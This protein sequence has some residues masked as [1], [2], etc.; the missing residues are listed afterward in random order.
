MARHLALAK[1]FA[2]PA[3]LTLLVVF[4]WSPAPVWGQATTED[5]DKVVY[6]FPPEGLSLEEAIQIAGTSTGRPFK[7]N[8]QD[9][10]NKPKI[11]V[12]GRIVVPRDRIYEFWQAI[13]VT[14]G[15][16]MVPMGPDAGDFI[17][18]ELVQT[19]QLIK[20][21]ANFVSVDEL[22]KYQSKA[23]EVIMTTIPLKH[24]KVDSVRNAVAQLMVNRTSEFSMEV[25]SANAMI[26]VG[27]APTVY[28][29]YQIMMAMDVPSSAATLKF[30]IVPLKNAVA[31]ELV[32]MLSELITTT[33]GAAAPGQPRAPRAP[34]E[35]VTAATEIPEPKI[36]ADPR[37]NAIVIYAVDA[38]M[39]EV[40]RLIA[41]LD[42]EVTSLDSNIR[43]F[44]LKNT[45]ADDMED[46]LKDLLQQQTSRTGRASNT[47]SAGGGQP[48]SASEIGQ[49]VTIVGDVHTNSLLITCTRTRFDEIAPIIEMLDKR[50]P[51]V[52]V[53]A[54]IAE[55]SDN[56]LRALGV[57]LSGIQGGSDRFRFGGLTG[58]G[59]SEIT[60]TGGG[61]GTGTGGTG[62]GGGSGTGTSPTLPTG[63]D[64]NNLARVPNVGFSGLLGGII[65]SDGTIPLLMSMMQTKQKVNLLSNASVLTNDNEMSHISVGREVAT[66][67]NS[68]DPSGQSRTGFQDYQKAELKLEISPHISTD[69][70]LRLELLLLVEAFVQ[71]S[72]TTGLP[73]DKT[74]REFKGSVTV[75]SGKTVVIGGLVQDNVSE[76]ETSVPFLSEIPLLGELFKSQTRNHERSTLYLFVTPTILS[77]F[78]T[79]ED[80]SYGTKMEVLRLHGNLTLVD[81]N[82]RAVG[83]DA[84][85]LNVEDIEESGDLDMPHYVP[86]APLEADGKQGAAT[87]QPA[88]QPAAPVIGTG[89]T[90]PASGR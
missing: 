4:A 42:T 80:I 39:S 59:L 13:F 6:T 70:Y 73:P 15:F 75:P 76:A 68:F 55:L 37:T 34:G 46:T 69:N 11:M 79:L 35:G 12:T 84:P 85:G 30:D 57:E 87:A 77:D 36:I 88:T 23:G 21:R 3:L 17:Q 5:K 60:P 10:K 2:I 31:E 51:Q 8:D 20:Q 50:R 61:S 67:Q 63:F 22:K 44:F 72:A 14:Q 24:V 82:F 53:H 49:E 71:N 56:A 38:D 27:F 28:A 86:T 18:V 45:N 58:F 32:A 29:V 78:K 41:A 9:F 26:I 64:F 1:G 43:I 89:S 81:P 19:S 83:F 25:P 7:F 33:G 74:S 66:A 54:A 90:P 62:T 65:Q 40:K 52:M 48:A 47:R 16:A